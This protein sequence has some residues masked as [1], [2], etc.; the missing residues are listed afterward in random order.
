MSVISLENLL[1]SGDSDRLGKLVDKAQNMGK[2]THI[3]QS[4]LDANLASS[5]IAANLRDGGELVLICES[6]AWAARLRY[7][8][9]TLVQAAR[10][11][12]LDASSCR[13]CVSRNQ[14]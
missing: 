7:E 2:L 10:D 5:L 6:S 14:A 3:L 8:A 11:A 1:K 13:V 12:G 9:D 4:A